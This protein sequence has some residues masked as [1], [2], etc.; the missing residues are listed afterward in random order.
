MKSMDDLPDVEHSF[1]FRADLAE[2]LAPP[3]NE[4]RFMKLPLYTLLAL[5]LSGCNSGG[6]PAV[7]NPPPVVAPAPPVAT[8]SWIAP[9]TN[10]D[11]SALTDLAGYTI[12]YSQSALTWDTI[13]LGVGVSVYVIDLPST[14]AWMFQMDA[15][16]SA[17][18]HS[19]RTP[20]ITKVFP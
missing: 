7:V 18:T 16:N 19:E 9:T 8:L 11:G 6:A 1:A 13:S 17:G 12:Y 10:T 2:L 4:E 14:G 15:V 20:P 3:A 5:L